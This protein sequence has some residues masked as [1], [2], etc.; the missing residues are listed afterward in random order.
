MQFPANVPDA[1]ANP[2]ASAIRR[3]RIMDG[4]CRFCH[5]HRLGEYL[6]A[7]MG[8]SPGIEELEPRSNFPVDKIADIR[9][10]PC[11]LGP[12]TKDFDSVAK[13]FPNC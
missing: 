10:H 5:E 2:R 13:L 9:I 11:T 3:L 4:M 8:N 7:F 12:L 6:D 1:A